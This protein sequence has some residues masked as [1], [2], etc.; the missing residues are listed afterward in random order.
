MAHLCIDLAFLPT[1]PTGLGTYALNLLA[2]LR[3]D[4]VVTLFSPRPLEPF[5]CCLVPPALAS[6]GGRWAHLARLAWQQIRLPALYRTH[7]A[8]LLFSPLPEAPLARHC[9][10]VVTVHDLIPLRFPGPFPALLTRYFQ[11][12]VPQVL[13]NSE[14]ILCDSEATASDI[15]RFYG[16]AAK[17]LTAIPLAHDAAHFYPRGLAPANYFLYLGR[18]DRHK[19]L[20]RMLQALACLKDRECE[21]WIAGP[22][23]TRQYPQLLARVQ[24]LNLGGRVRFLDYVPYMELPGLI[25]RAVALL[26]P[27]LWEGFGL[28]VL[29]AMACGTPVITSN[30]ASL[31]E[32]AADAALLVDP[33]RVGAIAAAMHRIL[34]EPGLRH[35]LQV[36]GLARA[37][38]FR[39]DRTARRTAE[40]LTCCL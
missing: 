34:N 35:Q 12:Y 23:D 20:D 16:I 24:H 8:D 36:Q 30:L 17:K 18:Q 15:V 4:D 32:I 6:D 37:S 33:Y 9:R 40:V 26:F 2:H 3:W 14:H 22:R 10:S 29:E 25:E 39:W 13:H 11:Y 7:K 38:L 21:F 1:R 5:P 19:N 28:P 31:S 27:T